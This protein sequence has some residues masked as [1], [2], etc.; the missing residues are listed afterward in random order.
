MQIYFLLILCVSFWAGNFV[1]G[2]FVR[3]ELDA[4]AL[5]YARW[6]CVS[7]LF[8]PLALKH[9]HN[10]LSSLKKHWLY[11]LITAFLSV[12]C[13]NTLLYQGLSTTMVTNAL[14]IN[15]SIPILIVLFSWLFLKATINR[16]QFIGILL[17]MLGV[18]YL[19]LSGQWSNLLTL[20]FNRGD[21]WV[22][23]SSLSW[24]TYS[25]LLRFK[26]DSIQAFLPIIVIL[27][28]LMLTP[29]FFLTGHHIEHLIA[30]STQGKLV[31]L[32]TAVFASILS[33]IFWGK[34]VA[35]I[36]AN[37][38]GQF[39]HLMLPLGVVFAYIFLGERMH[40]YHLYGFLLIGLGLWL[41]LFY[42]QRQRLS[43]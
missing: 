12:A 18:V 15:S 33:Y 14:M 7:V 10:I 20:S 21:I 8:L 13:F 39:T 36:G 26:P 37:K 5:A 41:S 34:G 35:S 32:Y 22:F 23:A 4:I 24:A 25:V 1:V 30:V 6:L 42:Q 38:T 19:A 2:R 31:I 27:G 29:L 9:R 43:Q 16:L 17:S 40:L 3:F 11:L 28:T